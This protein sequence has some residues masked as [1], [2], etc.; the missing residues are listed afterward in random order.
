MNENSILLF[1]DMG[2][3]TIV[4]FLTK[5][6]LKYLSEPCIFPDSSR[7][8][9]HLLLNQEN[10]VQVRVLIGYFL[11]NVSSKLQSFKNKHNSDKKHDG[12]YVFNYRKENLD[13]I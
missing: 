8:H 13:I 4:H 6:S 2:T 3:M 1:D 5:R 11:R 9:S 12:K 10:I 7:N